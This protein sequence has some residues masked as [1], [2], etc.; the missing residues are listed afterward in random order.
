[1]ENIFLKTK[2]RDSGVGMK[3]EELKL[4]FQ[5]Y[6]KLEDK[7]HIN[8]GG[9]GLGLIISKNICERLGG[10]MQVYSELGIGTKFV[11]TIALEHSI[12]DE[13]CQS[14]ESN[15]FEIDPY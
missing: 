9:L 7:K 6:G 12:S 2:V 10:S 1:M 14:E 4:L 11:F 15:L 13:N 3:P 8:K 5:H